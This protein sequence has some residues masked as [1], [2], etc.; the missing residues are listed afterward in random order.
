MVGNPTSGFGKVVGPCITKEAQKNRETPKMTDAILEIPAQPQ[1]PE[2]PPHRYIR[3]CT[4]PHQVALNHNQNSNRRRWHTRTL[5]ASHKDSPCH[6]TN[7]T[8][9]VIKFFGFHL[10][11]QGGV[12]IYLLFP[13]PEMLFATDTCMP[14]S[15]NFSVRPSLAIQCKITPSPTHPHTPY[16]CFIFLHSTFHHLAYYTFNLFAQYHP[17]PIRIF[18]KAR[19]LV[20]FIYC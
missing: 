11:C 6:F 7:L 18:M 15:L 3:Q 19:I 14:H 1:D 20:C 2:S 13:L 8:F 10:S 16:S 12:L 5:Q 17:Y 4:H 9:Y